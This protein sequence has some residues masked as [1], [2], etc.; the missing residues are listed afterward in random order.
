MTPSR[1]AGALGLLVLASCG[2]GERPS[3][4]TVVVTTSLLEL[5]VRDAAGPGVP[6]QVVR[7]LPPGSCPGH[8]DLSPRVLPTLRAAAAVV[9]HDYQ[10]PLD[11]KI[12]RAG[13]DRAVPLAVGAPGSLLIPSNYLELVRRVAGAL[14]GRVPGISPLP[15]AAVAERLS[16]LERELRARPRPWEGRPA[17]ASRHQKDFAEWLGL[18]VTGAL[19]RPDDVTPAQLERLTHCEA[20][21]VVANLQEGVQAALALAGRRGLPAAVFSN[22]PGAE[23]YGTT[24]EDLLRENVRR[25]EEAWAKR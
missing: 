4:P 12:R 24:Y 2:G 8:F 17:V 1:S 19:D 3:P 23:G 9:R 10:G 13:A 7:L 16:A 15:P 25:L 14:Q 22:F 6:L 21:V 18:R 11:E 5:A 20:E